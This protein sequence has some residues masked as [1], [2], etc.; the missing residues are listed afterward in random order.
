LARE[1]C[2][3]LGENRSPA[4]LRA[5]SEGDVALDGFMIL[6]HGT[7][8]A[9]FVRRRKSREPMFVGGSTEATAKAG[10]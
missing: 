5:R 8:A 4:T 6:L 7:R 1:G 2:P 3:T 9:G 10:I